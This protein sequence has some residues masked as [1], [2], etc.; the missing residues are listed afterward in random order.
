M[1]DPYGPTN[2]SRSGE[3]R[4]TPLFP[5]FPFRM[6]SELHFGRIFPKMKTPLTLWISGV[7]CGCGGS[8]QPR[9]TRACRRYL[10]PAQPCLPNQGEA[11]RISGQIPPVRFDLKPDRRGIG[12]VVAD[13]HHITPW[14]CRSGG[15]SRKSPE[16]SALTTTA[17][18]ASAITRTNFPPASEYSRNRK[19][20]PAACLATHERC[21]GIFFRYAWQVY[22]STQSWFRL[23]KYMNSC[24]LEPP[25]RIASPARY[26]LPIET[27]KTDPSTIS[28]L[29]VSE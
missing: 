28:F 15:I 27:Q 4:Y 16:I 3:D 20:K 5:H 9:P 6:H 7:L 1:P 8:L 26:S 23:S 22:I 21:H 18:T 25:R 12:D 17:L 11:N 13:A 29:S 2:E 10:T 19:T 14:P 24:E